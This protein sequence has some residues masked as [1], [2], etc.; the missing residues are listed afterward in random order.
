MSLSSPNSSRSTHHM[1]NMLMAHGTHERTKTLRNCRP[2]ELR[3]L[4]YQ[5]A[6][7]RQQAEGDG[8]LERAEHAPINGWM[9]SKNVLNLARR[10][11]SAPTTAA[12]SLVYG[13]KPP[14]PSMAC[15]VA[16]CF[17]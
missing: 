7:T 2:P 13:S 14:K 16:S 11:F 4:S 9:S 1:A 6:A 3:A 8:H 17:P 15:N 12:L 5:S 10:A